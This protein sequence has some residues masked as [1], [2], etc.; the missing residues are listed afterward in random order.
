MALLS[1]GKDARKQGTTSSTQDEHTCRW[2]QWLQLLDI[3]EF[4]DDPY[5]VT[6][7]EPWQHT[8]LISAFTQALREANFSASAFTS[9]A[10]GTV[11]ATVD[12]MAQAFRHGQRPY[13]RLDDD[14]K[15]L[16]LLMQKY[17]GYH[18][19]NKNVKQQKALL[20]IVLHQLI[21]TPS[22]IENTAI[23]QLCTGAFFFTMRSCEYLHTNIAE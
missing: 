16:I 20:L 9:L 10:E 8:I 7:P 18:N 12:Y 19:L 22:S 21:K 17:R 2:S 14:G 3:L 6:I 13:P 15:L 1:A 5:L 23:A 11:Q 4:K